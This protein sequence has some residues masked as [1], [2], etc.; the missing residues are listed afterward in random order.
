MNILLFI[1]GISFIGLFVLFSCK[2][3]A[4]DE[5]QKTA[6]DKLLQLK[7]DSYDERVA[8][9]FDF[10]RAS[11]F[12]IPFENCNN[13]L[14]LQTNLCNSCNVDRIEKILNTLKTTKDMSYFILAANSIEIE[15]RIKT[16]PIKAKVFV[17]SAKLLGQY[18]LSLL[19]NLNIR[20]CDK[21]IIAWSFL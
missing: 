7:N 14:V 5:S 2:N 1:R 15:M 11:N 16:S 13:I 18:N 17:D 3:S 19:K 9:I 6:T 12:V 4:V 10:V 21:K 20:I 8:N